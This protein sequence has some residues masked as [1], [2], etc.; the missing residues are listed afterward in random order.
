M[1]LDRT[2]FQFY[3]KIERATRMESGR[4]NIGLCW[5][6][7]NAPK[8]PQNEPH[9]GEINAQCFERGLERLAAATL[10]IAR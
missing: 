2:E 9:E 5:K 1:T 10:G 3:W 6:S 7:K 8:N 4:F